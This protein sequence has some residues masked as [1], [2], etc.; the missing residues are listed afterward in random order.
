VTP[1]LHPIGGDAVQLPTRDRGPAWLS[2]LDPTDVAAVVERV[3]ALAVEGGTVV[4]AAHVS[5]DGDALGAALALHLGLR[6]L[7]IDSVPTV[8]E[9]PLKVPAP[10][11][12]LQGVADLVD[13]SALPAPADIAALITVDVSTPDRLGSVASLVEAGVPTIVLDHHASGSEFG[14]L[15]LIAP[16]AAATVQLAAH[17]LDELAIPLDLAMATWLYAGLV[18]DTGRFSHPSTDDAVMVLAGRLLA[19]GVDHAE[20]TRKLYD[21]RSLSA[22]RLLG[23]ALDRLRFVPE[24]ALV[25]TYVTHDELLAA[26]TGLEATEALIDLVRSADVAEVALVLKPDPDG[27]WRGSLRSRGTVD[28]GA[29]A[30]LLGGG[31]H[32]LAA[33]FTA[34]GDPEHIVA[35]VVDHLRRA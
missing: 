34:D 26:G 35:T 6:S 4:L 23:R 13:G 31:G 16:G 15:R 10:L 32:A 28:V 29:V 3:R 21:T 24:V 17:L 30:T 11:A 18:T 9:H 25:T 14:D 2:E 1:V 19:V 22:L 27:S 12:D 20:L 8:G 33:G 7:G 5:P